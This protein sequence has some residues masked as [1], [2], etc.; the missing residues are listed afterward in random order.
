MFSHS[1]ASRLLPAV[2]IRSVLSTARVGSLAA[3]LLMLAACGGEKDSGTYDLSK[4]L[5]GVLGGGRMKALA[6]GTAAQ[7]GVLINEV[8]AANWKGDADED[9]DAEDWLELYNPAGTEV[10][11]SGYGLTNNTRSPFRWAFPAGQKIGPQAYLRVWLSKKNRSTLGQPLH[12]SFNLDNGADS[13]FLSAS[14]ATA[15]GILVDSTKPALVKPDHSWCRM[16]SGLPG[17][18]FQICAQPTAAAANAGPAFPSMLAKPVFSVPSGLYAAAQT[19]AITGPAGA[20]VRFTT[21]GSMPTEGSPVYTGPLSVASNQA[22]RAAAF[23]AN[24][25]SSPA[26]SQSYVIDSA[27][28]QRY[29]S[30]KVAFVVMDPADLARFQARDDSLEALV[31]LE[32]QDAGT[33]LIKQ[34]A[35]GSVSGNL[36]SVTSPQVS[37]NANAKD[38]FG[39]K[40]FVSAGV[41]WASKPANTTTKKLRLRNGGNDWDR[42][43]VRDLLAQDLASAG[44]NIV[45][46][47]TPMVMF[48][49][50]RYY[51]QMNLREREDETSVVDNRGADKDYVD[52]LENPPGPQ[53][54]NGG[55]AALNGYRRSNDFIKG[56]DM[57]VPANFERAKREVDLT[58]LAWDWGHHLLLANYDWPHN[59]VYVYRSPEL[60]S[61]WTWRPHD[62]DFAFGR[63]AGPERNMN[64]RYSAVNS[65]M[66]MSLMRNPEFRNLFLNVAADQMNLMTPTFMNARLDAKAAEMRPYINDHFAAN[67]QGGEATWNTHVSAIRN[68]A[69][70]REPFHDLHLRS[71]FNL[72]NR[73]AIGVAVNDRAMGTVKVNTLDVGAQMG[74]ANAWSGKYYAGVPITLEALPKPGFVFVGWQ[75]ASASTGR[76]ITHTIAP[77][78]ALPVDGFAVRWSGELAVPT[79]GVYRFQVIADDGV[80]LSINGQTLV[81]NVAPRAETT[82]STAAVNLTAGQRASITVQYTDISGA[83]SMRLL[84]LPPGASEYV[85]VPATQFYPDAAAPYPTGL[86]GAYYNN[87]DFT[88]EPVA[89]AV[90]HIDFAWGAQAPSP[91]NAEFVAVFAPGPAPSAPALAAVA[92]KTVAT[93]DLVNI[94]LVA[95]DS[96]G[97]TLSFSATGLPRG[98]GINARTG[99]IFGRLTT[100]GSYSAVVTVTNGG[101]SATLPITWTVTDRPGTGALGTSADSGGPAPNTPPTVALTAP[102]PGLSI[103]SGA[104]VTVSA[105]AADSNGSVARVEFFD[106]TTLIG[107]DTTAPYAI[108]WSSTVV[109]SHTLTARATDDQGATT[110][111]AAVSVTVQAAVNTPPTVAITTPTPGQAIANGVAVTV[112]ANAAD[113]NGSVARVE[114]FDGSTLIGADTTAPYSISWSSTA[115]GNHTLSARATD[116]LGAATTSAPVT[117]SVAAPV[118]VPNVPPT[119][120]L[121]APTSGQVLANGAALALSATAADS[122]GSVARVEFYDGGA[123]LT[124]ITAAP[125]LGSVNL[126]VPGP[127]TITA[128]AIDNRGASASGAAADVIVA[129]AGTVP[130]PAGAVACAGEGGVCALPAGATATVYFGGSGHFFARAGLSGSVACSNSGFGDPLVSLG[131]ACSYVVTGAP[132]V[133]GAP[134]VGVLKAEFWPNR[135]FSGAPAVTRFELPAMNLGASQAPDPRLPTSGFAVRWSGSFTPT[136]TGRHRFMLRTSTADGARMWVNGTLLIDTWNSPDTEEEG[137]LDLKAGKA[138][139]IRIEFFDAGAEARLALSW[140][141]PGVETFVAVPAS[142]FNSNAPSTATGLRGDYFNGTALGTVPQFTRIEAVDFNWGL[143]APSTAVPQD[144]FS[145]RWTGYLVVPTTG[146]YQFQ[147]VSDN[148][149]RLSL[150]NVLRISNWASHSSRT[151]T[152]GSLFLTAGQRVPVKLEYYEQTGVAEMRFRWRRP[153]SS[154]FVAVP[155]SALSPE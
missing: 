128:R 127:H 135:T 40:D 100:P 73:G 36:G 77:A 132:V 14:N 71:Q 9:G 120:V 23:A 15:A 57:S 141:A 16:P 91:S 114:F 146:S 35:N 21:D 5:A 104:A 143:A 69:K 103:T 84:W 118:P 107:T 147:T 46:A 82:V 70:L 26:E 30:L 151:D 131:K 155:T 102:T 67:G 42:A 54:K 68:W 13:I 56:N 17:S 126:S 76:N 139:A 10:D 47:S 66:F 112:S 32:L 85:P 92:A 101:S 39:P 149:V 12:A 94:P 48:M 51:G 121:V 34:D 133:P 140:R 83:A 18:A 145:V 61:R 58:S 31:N 74:G 110:T 136:A 109:G 4:G 8:H 90:E 38:V 119:V 64:D 138:V 2:Q 87:P 148:G 33:R 129:S 7:G 122:D 53:I 124:T 43:R 98:V 116:D 115:T 125:F 11:L 95:T 134:G 72:P 106:G 6:A 88:G 93:G 154:S 97:H 1:S 142:R 152:S 24:V 49:N 25:L 20:T 52:F 81:S 79:T 96:N 65:Q 111:S 144:N 22:I 19:V 50:G 99:I 37:L 59:N 123:L 130:L 89:T 153:G 27:L 137:R 45:G 28:A 60:G 41:L 75:G 108:N 117:V 44:P 150:N 78:A 105:N 63:Y 62:F 86:F 55:L 80:G 29:S 113:S 3:A